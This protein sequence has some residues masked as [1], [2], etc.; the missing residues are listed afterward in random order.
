MTHRSDIIVRMSATL[1]GL[2][3]IA[4]LGAASAQSLDRLSRADANGDGAIE[5]QE[6]LAMRETMFGRLDR[7]GD[8]FAD[9]DDRPGFGPATSR[10]DAALQN[11]MTAADADGDGRISKAEMV[12]APA[13]LFTSGDTDEN[14]IL[15]ADEIASLSAEAG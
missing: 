14:G 5:W 6:V 13:P 10:F 7:N 11:L 1:G 4:S 12:N 2:A 8:G 15:S 3:L 9:M